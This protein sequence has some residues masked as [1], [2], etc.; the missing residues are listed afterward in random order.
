MQ[1]L[2]SSLSFGVLHQLIDQGS[3]NA[4]SSLKD[5]KEGLTVLLKLVFV[6]L[7]EAEQSLEAGV[8]SLFILHGE[9]LWDVIGHETAPTF[10]VVEFGDVADAAH[11]L[12][13]DDGLLAFVHFLTN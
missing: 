6:L 11:I 4:E 13:N 9:E 2:E 8:N 5:P 7:D 10:G 12:L 3:Q 1:D